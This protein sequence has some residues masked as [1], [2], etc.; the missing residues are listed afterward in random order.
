MEKNINNIK[1]EFKANGIFYT[2]PELVETMKSYVDFEPRRVY[3]PTC[4]QGNLLAAF[5]DNVEKY[6]QEL[7]QDELDKASERLTNFHGYC[8]DTLKADGFKGELFDCIMANP[9]FSVKW[10]PQNDDI[11]WA[12]APCT[13]P[14]GKA[15]F[16]FVCHVLHHLADDGK[17]VVMCFPGI[18]Y[19]GQREGK[20]RQWMVEQNF[21]E[22]VVHIPGGA[23]TDT[24]IATA[25]LVLS[26]HK[27][28]TDIIFENRE[29]GKERTVTIEEVKSNDYNLSV[30]NYVF[31]EQ[32]KEE[33]DPVALEME[34]RRLM[35]FN[36]ENKLRLT[37]LASAFENLDSDS[38]IDDIIALAEKYRTGGEGWREMRAVYPGD[39]A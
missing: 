17:A 3:D 37:V 11:R 34:A 9:P 23:F 31:E 16:A 28:N 15:D 29:I 12:D 32:K 7:Y 22:R 5:P 1:K 21:V 35:M 27:Q 30:T 18:L 26:K 38:L 8:G 25:V 14:P 4:G 20:I 13:A 2:P 33:I 39:V 19:R 24:T 36:L 6:G 10:E